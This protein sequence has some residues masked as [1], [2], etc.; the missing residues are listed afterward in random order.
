LSKKGALARKQATMLEVNALSDT[1][2][3][4]FRQFFQQADA[5]YVEAQKR[6]AAQP[7]ANMNFSELNECMQEW[8]TWIEVREAAARA[9]ET[10]LRRKKKPPPADIE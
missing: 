4:Q 3:G 9:L 7:A 1:L 5:L 2:P 6:L 8:L 10:G